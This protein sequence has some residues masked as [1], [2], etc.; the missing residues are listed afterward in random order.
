[1]L[2][3]TLRRARV[4]GGML[5]AVVGLIA[6]AACLVGI[7]TLLLSVSQ[8]RAFHVAIQRSQPADVDV[9]AFLVDLPGSELPDA[10]GR[11]ERVVTDVLAPMRPTV[12]TSAFGPMR[13]LAGGRVAYLGT[14]DRFADRA[15]LTSGHW[16]AGTRGGR[17]EAVVPETAARLLGL[18]LGDTVTLG[19]EL[20]G[21]GTTKPVTVVVVGTFQPRLGGGW[22]T[23]PL[24]G[25]GYTQAWVHG[26]TSPP[27]YGP[28]VVGATTFRASGSSVAGMRVTAHPT[29]AL[30]RR[31]TLTAAAEGLDRASALLTAGVGDR[32]QITRVAS[33]LPA[34]L[35]RIEAEQAATRSTVLV[36]VLLGVALSIV[37]ALLAGWLVASR[38]DD[39]R[40]LLLAL[41]LSRRQQLGA[42]LMEAG[43]LAVAAAILAVPAAAVIHA[44]LS[45]RPGPRT[46]GLTQSPTITAALVIAVVATSLL[47]AVTLVLTAL[48]AETATDRRARPRAMVRGGLDAL[49]V[50]IAVAGWWQL[51][52]QAGES[53]SG[54]VVL[55]AA[56]V[57]CLA[58]LT[59]L[60][61]RLVPSALAALGHAGTRSRGLVLALAV[62]QAARR[63]H[64]GTAMV[65]I[66]AAV[67]AATFGIGLRA[68]WQHSQ[69]DQA[70]L[71][72]GTD[73]S[74]VPAA[75][76]GRAAA[77]AIES[78]DAAGSLG[79][80]VSP[81]I[82]RTVAL[83]SFVGGAGAPSL[84]VGV[85]STRAAELLRGRLTDGTTWGRIGALLAPTTAAR[86]IA[87]PPGGAGMELEG[88][89]PVRAGLQVTPTAVLQDAAGLRSSVSAS[90]VPLDGHAHPVTWLGTIDT[91]QRLAGIRLA[92]N[93]PGTHD[94]AAPV[95]VSLRIPGASAS[96]SG[97]WQVAPMPEGGLLTGVD[98]TVASSGSDTVVRTTATANL[99]YF[100]YG[101][102]TVLATGFAVPADVPV[103]ASQALVDAVGAEVGSRLTGILNGTAVELRVAAIVPEVPSAPG[104]AAV[105]A[106]VD[107]L[108]RALV[109]AG[110]LDPGVDAWWIAAPTPATVDG[111]RHLA[112]GEVT[113]RAEVAAQLADGPVRV[114]VPI[115]LVTLEAAAALLLLMSVGLLLA[116]HQPRRSEEVARLRALG[117]SSADAR[118]IMVAENAAFLV[119]LVLVGAL[120]GVAA[121]AV[122]G[123]RLI[124]SDVGGPPVPP[125][126]AAWPWA[127]ETLFVAGVA[128]AALALGAVLAVVHVRHADPAHVRIEGA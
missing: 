47:L 7:C 17:P 59:L 102:S 48:D 29:L 67:A 124:R 34:T 108:S 89:A 42:A 114:A 77:T 60:A 79:T 62:Q 21:T 20:D 65:A 14:D 121:S 119:P 86:V 112:L 104:R 88:T 116:S 53:T 94:S 123:P 64:S 19:Q 99:T 22:D 16:P 107:M 70:A 71:L 97:S 87:L 56:P 28:F 41:G 106:D 111:V 58:A 24:A 11:A 125:A 98:V 31:S 122:L 96:A 39:E 110:D 13:Q 83:G 33:E 115:A 92:L 69:D 25:Q 105:L 90:A 27:A 50:L 68:T 49:L 44:L 46:A 63:P 103:A 32:V 5:A 36:V 100:G 91:G 76:A 4:Q 23:D 75:T 9:T 6:A 10:R 117:S 1:M 45:H 52:S 82:D 18:R 81:V 26:S 38:R 85:D 74:L 54:D 127:A 113:T 126:V 43:L 37:A 55:T 3:L 57:V 72:T 2:T 95:S 30:A 8:E 12:T 61:V 109:D 73:L 93:G 35:D 128:L 78:A 101:S 120:A 51:R 66:A 15:V 40:A 118:R 84:V 80:A